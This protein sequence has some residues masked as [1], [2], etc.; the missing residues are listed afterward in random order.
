MDRVGLPDFIFL[1]PY[2]L[3]FIYLK[4]SIL[5][6]KIH[7]LNIHL[8]KT[9]YCNLLDYNRLAVRQALNR[10][11]QGKLPS[12]LL[13]DS[14]RSRTVTLLR[15]SKGKVEGGKILIPPSMNQNLPIFYFKKS[16]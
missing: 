14:E 15:T 8:S 2:L 9:N 10:T 7:L 1:K 6:Q 12:T 11:V 5:R 16:G 3:F 13:R 4:T